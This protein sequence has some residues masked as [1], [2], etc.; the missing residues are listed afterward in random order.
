MNVTGDAMS[1]NP[2]QAAAA[3]LIQAQA[4]LDRALAELDRLPALDIHS[5][6]LAAHAL[7]NFLSIS[8]GVVGLLIA[9]LR[10][11]ADSQV[12][13]WLEGLGHATD[14]MDHTVSQ[15]MNNTVGVDATL[16][17]ED[18]DVPRLVERACAYYRRAAARK[19][20]QLTLDAAPAVAL[21]R[22]DR[23]LLAAVVDNL[24]SNAVKYSPK[25]GRIQVDV[26]EERDGIACSV[27]DDG[28]GLSEEEQ[29]RLFLPGVRLSPRPS[30]GEASTGYGL[31]IAKRF[32]D[33]LGGEVSCA[34][35]RGKGA[36]FSLWLPGGRPGA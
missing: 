33:L 26:R 17:L 30:G 28:P 1:G 8:R 35:A 3:A 36:T 9:S 15:L 21:V 23:V 29:A 22:T 34:S 27:R 13:A 5:I 19:G 18:V 31:A 25:D 16:R 32:V 24:L 10:D 2:K 7:N 14:L 12:M 4:N 11:R 20:I 6:A